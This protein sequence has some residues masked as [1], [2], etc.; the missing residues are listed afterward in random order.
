MAS[1]FPLNIRYMIMA[2]PGQDNHEKLT[3]RV[4]NETIC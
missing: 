2:S 4:Y 3:S 1:P